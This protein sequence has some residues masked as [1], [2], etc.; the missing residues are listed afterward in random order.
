M[1]RRISILIMLLLA[2][3]TSTPREGSGSPFESGSLE[4]SVQGSND[5]AVSQVIRDASGSF[6]GTLTY[7]GSC[8]HMRAELRFAY[9]RGGT[10][11]TAQAIGGVDEHFELQMAMN[12]S[13]SN[14]YS[15]EDQFTPDA[16]VFVISSEHCA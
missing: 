7:S 11:L 5:I 3:C 2:A 10:T 16:I 4:A 13:N 12:E 9:E 6:R 14:S 8:S 1:G 15:G